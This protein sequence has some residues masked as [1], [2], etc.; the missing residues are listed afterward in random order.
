[1]ANPDACSR[2]YPLINL[3][4]TIRFPTHGARAIH[5]VALN[6]GGVGATCNLVADYSGL[7]SV[8]PTQ[9]TIQTQVVG[10]SAGH[11]FNPLVR[12]AP[13]SAQQHLPDVLIIQTT[14]PMN[15]IVTLIY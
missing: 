11:V 12:E 7:V 13:A 8:A 6:P 10:A 3:N 1:M 14:A 2:T 4:G 5:V 9:V 15:V